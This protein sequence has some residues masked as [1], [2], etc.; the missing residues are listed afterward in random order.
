M[1]PPKGS[2]EITPNKKWTREW[3]ES[4]FI[5]DRIDMAIRQGF[6]FST[7]PNPTAYEVEMAKKADEPLSDSDTE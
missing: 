7:L 6:D 2:F 1:M 3:V 5:G 4:T